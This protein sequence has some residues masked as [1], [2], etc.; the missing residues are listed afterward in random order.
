MIRIMHVT[1]GLTT[2]GAEM[3]LLRL[4][5]ANNGDWD[6]AVVSLMDE[7]TIGSRI[8]ALGIPVYSLGMRR[9]RPDPVRALSIVSLTRRVRPHLIVGWMYHGNLMASLAGAFSPTCVPVFWNIQ[10]ALDNIAGWGQLTAAVIRVGAYLSRYPAA[11]IYNTQV[12]A[13]QHE[14][15]GYDARKRIIIPPGF[16]CQ[17]FHPDDDARR[18]FRAELGVSEDTVL[19]GLVARYHPMKDHTGFL[20][21]ASIVARTHPNVLF[22]LLGKGITTEG[23]ALTKLIG[24]LQLE[25]RILLLGERTDMPRVTAVLDI[26]CSASAWGEGFSNAVGEAMACGIPCVVTDVGDSSY[27]V[28]N[29]GLSVPPRDPQA[30][31]QA[32]GRLIDAGA[33]ARRQLGTA[34]RRRV[35]SEFSLP[36]ITGQYEDLYREHLNLRVSTVKSS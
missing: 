9:G 7:G 6:P 27:A 2:G 24:E 33:T 10:Q 13:K 22:L 11:I 12:G 1:T 20:R 30:L 8:V 19:I 31:A 16:D 5:S 23:Q 18:Q 28:A 35:E 32:I 15:F 3:M 17:T 29:T 4:L 36:A 14:A 26:A 21:A 34:A 25:S